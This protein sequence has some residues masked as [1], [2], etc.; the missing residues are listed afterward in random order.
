MSQIRANDPLAVAGHAIELL[1]TAD[2][3]AAKLAYLLRESARTGLSG[4]H[5]KDNQP[6]AALSA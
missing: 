4:V 2:P 5:L 1:A 3:A 6:S